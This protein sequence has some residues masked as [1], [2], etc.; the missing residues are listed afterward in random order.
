MLGHEDVDL[1][2]LLPAPTEEGLQVLNRR[3]NKV[4]LSCLVSIS[5]GTRVPVGAGRGKEQEVRM[6]ERDGWQQGEWLL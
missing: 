3:N 4:L 6:E 1:F 2:T 5:S